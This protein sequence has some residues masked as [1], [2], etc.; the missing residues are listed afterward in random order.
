MLTFSLCMMF[1]DSL[2]LESHR[3]LIYLLR[4]KDY[5]NKDST[6]IHIA[7]TK[8][9]NIRLEKEMR[10]NNFYSQAAVSLK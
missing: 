10:K 1:E 8:Q 3:F 4:L 2:K 7:S 9:L 5:L 6:E